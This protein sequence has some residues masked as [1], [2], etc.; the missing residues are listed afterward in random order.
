MNPLRS[1]L[2]VFAVLGRWPNWERYFDL[3]RSGL[4]VSLF[5]LALCLAPLWLVAWSIQLE[6]ASL[7]ETDFVSPDLLSYVLTVGLLLFSFPVDYYAQLVGF[8][9]LGFNGGG[10]WIIF[11]WGPAFCHCQWHWLCRLYGRV[12]RGYSSRPKSCRL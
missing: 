3:S 9:S 6:R 10:L 1:C 7:L 5:I 8:L 4:K 11:A 2:G 12:S